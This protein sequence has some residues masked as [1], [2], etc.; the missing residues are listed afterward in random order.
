MLPMSDARAQ[1]D[2]GPA[3]EPTTPKK[4]T[5]SKSDKTKAKKIQACRYDGP[6]GQSSGSTKAA[7]T[8]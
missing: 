8:K 2:Q 5:K 7:I 6:S 1:T 4:K 3:A